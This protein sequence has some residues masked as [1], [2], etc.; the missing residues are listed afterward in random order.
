M[1]EAGLSGRVDQAAV[2]LRAKLAALTRSHNV[3]QGKVASFLL[4][5][6]YVASNYS[7]T[8]LASLAGV[9]SGTVSTLCKGLGLRGYS[10]FRFALAR[11]AVAQQLNE[12][13]PGRQDAEAG[14]PMSDAERAI[15]DAFGADLQA[16]AETESLLDARQLQRA[17]TL[18]QRAAQV[19]LVGIA[20][21]AAI[22]NDA[23]IKLRKVGIRASFEADSHSQAMSA[24]L[25]APGDAL[26]AISHSGRT[27]EIL[28]AAKLA[29]RAGA[30]VIAVVALGPSPLR[31]VADVV[32]PIVAHDTAFRVEPTASSVAALAIVHALFLLLFTVEAKAEDTYQ[33]TLDAV[34]VREQR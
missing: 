10:E 14:T 17:A 9:S 22:A 13:H 33:R 25:L 8:E 11:E 34:T 15:R 23:A 19:E 3:A 16:L 27:M 24:S 5:Q 31:D 7:I 1:A 21:S 26:L 32:L 30:S 4:D 29:K 18:I 28:R 2:S 12:R 20:S 6:Y